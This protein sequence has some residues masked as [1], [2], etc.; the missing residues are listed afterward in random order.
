MFHSSKSIHIGFACFLAGFLF[1][2]QSVLAAAAPMDLSSLGAWIKPDPRLK[3]I[4]D[5]DDESSEIRVAKL[6]A[7]SQA[8]SLGTWQSD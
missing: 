3:L 5:V 8:I 6:N 7:R 4:C 1:L 2:C